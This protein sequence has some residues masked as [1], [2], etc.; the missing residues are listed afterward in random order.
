MRCFNKSGALLVAI[1]LGMASVLV[2]S[3]C[4]TPGKTGEMSAF[5]AAVASPDDMAKA[6]KEDGRVA[7]SGGLVFETDSAKLAPSAA[8]LVKRISTMMKKNPDVKIAVV[9]HTDSTGDYKYNL[10]LSE[11]RAK[12]VV[13]A[14]EKDG[15]AATRLA[16]VGVGPLMP[17]ASDDTPEGREQNRRVV[18]VLAR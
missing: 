3:G 7:I 14:L 4:T 5:N 10:Q 16:A 15:V 18:L 6:L 17:A 11:R 13:D 2:F 8:D 12:A 1:S 9:G